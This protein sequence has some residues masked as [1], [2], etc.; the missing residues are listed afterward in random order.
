MHR[1]VAGA[2]AISWMAASAANSN[3]LVLSEAE[4]TAQR[5]RLA[6]LGFA[7]MLER[8]KR[9]IR[10]SSAIRLHGAALCND[11]QSPVTGI[12]AAT[13]A[14]LP[15]AYRETAYRDHGVEDLLKVLWILP[16]YP[17]TEAGLRSGDTILEIDGRETHTAAYLDQR[18]PADSKTFTAVKI[19]RGGEI[20][21]LQF[22]AR[23]GCFRPAVLS[24]LDNVDAHTEGARMVVYSGM[25]RFTESDDELAIVL[26]HELAHGLLGRELSVENAESEADYL[27]LYLVARAGYDV[28]V[29]AEFARR[30]GAEFP[31]ALEERAGHIHPISAARSIALAD[32]LREIEGKL[33]RGEP[34]EPRTQ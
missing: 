7:L 8:Q 24:V 4:V 9:L 10:V 15:E 12:V 34:L 31:L 1:F 13:S 25:L 5:E 2:L 28:A 11:Q 17:A 22:E 16:D 14:E 18:N 30:L 19:E 21:D 3:D 20:F 32:T 26:A 29:A 23:N 27:G 33:E 6:R